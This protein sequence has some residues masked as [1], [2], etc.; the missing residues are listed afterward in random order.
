[1]IVVELKD[2]IR[3]QADVAYIQLES[4]DTNSIVRDTGLEPAGRSALHSPDF[5]A[6]MT[7]LNLQSD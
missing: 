2:N 3:T 4:V 1:M 7:R 5:V 6:T